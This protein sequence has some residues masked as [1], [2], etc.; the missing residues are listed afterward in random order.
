MT[1]IN[2]LTNKY[3]MNLTNYIIQSYTNQVRNSDNV[4]YT[5]VMGSNLQGIGI[6]ALSL[7]AILNWT[8]A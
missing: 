5:A 6:C 4:V 3:D 1:I 7:N 2:I 8:E